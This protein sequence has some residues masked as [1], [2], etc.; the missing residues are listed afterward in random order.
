M[1]IVVVGPPCAGKSTWIN[2]RAR[3]TD[4]VIDYDRIAMAL[5]GPRPGDHD[6]SP[7]VEAVTKAARSA[8]I[9]AAMR[10]T[11]AV[12]VYLIH[13]N[14][15]KAQ[16]ATYE[17]RGARVVVLDPGI[18][19][20]RERA[21]AERPGRIYTVIDQWY[22][23]QA[24]GG[25]EERK[26][27]GNQPGAV[28]PIGRPYL[29]ARKAV[30]ELSDVCHLCGHR[31]ADTVDHLLPRSL[32]GSVAD[33]SNLAPAHGVTGCPTCGVRCNQVRGNG[34]LRGAPVRS[35]DW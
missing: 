21:K 22:R 19:V 17:R 29:R 7:I 3:P 4:I 20:V 15:S 23:D 12:D 13:S 16:R 25:W 14:P 27:K 35:R 30:L 32:G 34:L 18:G 1:L 26:P 2:E 10:H 33:P 31:G 9:A 28:R 11:G 5:S 6:H 24:E 8:A